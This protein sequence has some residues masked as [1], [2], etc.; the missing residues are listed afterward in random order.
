MKRLLLFIA[1]IAISYTANCQYNNFYIG[2]GVYDFDNPTYGSV[3]SLTDRSIGN[4]LGYLLILKEQNFNLILPYHQLYKP[5]YKYVSGSPSLGFLDRAESL[6]IKVIVNCPEL[7]VN[8]SIPS[9]YNSS[10]GLNALNYYGNH[11]AVLGWEIVDE[12]SKNHFS[13]IHDISNAIQ[14]FNSAKLRFTNLYPMYADNEQLFGCGWAE[15]SNYD[16]PNV[17]GWPSAADYEG[18]VEDFISDTNPNFLSVDYYPDNNTTSFFLNMDIIAKKAQ[19]LP[20]FIMLNLAGFQSSGSTYIGKGINEFNYV[21]YGSLA[22]GAKGLFYWAREQQIGKT[23]IDP[24]LVG[25]TLQTIGTNRWDTSISLITKDL[26]SEL[27][28]KFI[29]NEKTLLSLQFKSAYHKS[30]VSTINTSLTEQLPSYSSWSNFST[31]IYA[32]EIFNVSNPITLIDGS[33]I[34]NIVIS[35]LIDEKSNRY[36]WIFNKSITEGVKIQMNFKENTALVDVLEGKIYPLAASRVV[37]LDP[38]QAK[39]F[40][41]N[42]N[43]QTNFSQCTRN[44]NSGTYPDIW[45]QNISVGGPGCTVRYYNG[46]KINYLADYMQINDGVTIYQGSKVTFAGEK[47]SSG[48]IK[49]SFINEEKTSKSEFNDDEL[50]I[51]IYPNPTTGILFIFSGSDED[52]IKSIEILNLQGRSVFGTQINYEKYIEINLVDKFDKGIYFISILT[53]KNNYINKLIFE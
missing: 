3:P 39:L 50:K 40:G 16:Y 34:N 22:Y 25:T 53:Q 43:Y 42:K 8:K 1:F 12:P 18:Y 32:N 31:D 11:P 35:F 4:D 27:H 15:G 41:I 13:L 10:M 47:L 14:S 52:L 5:S 45:A 17:T 30:S 24:T 26:L 46:A 29:R 36:F 20:Y 6:G 33:T 9:A 51:K 48:N 23:Q 37:E 7:N 44:F 49:S 38:G 28:S 2:M 21:I 19:N